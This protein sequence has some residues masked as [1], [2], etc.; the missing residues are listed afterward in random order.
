MI[1]GFLLSKALLCIAATSFAQFSGNYT[2]HGK[3]DAYTSYKGKIKVYLSKGIDRENG[4]IFDSA[5]LV[6]GSFSFAGTIAEPETQTITLKHPGSG[7]QDEL[8][9]VLENGRT[10]INTTKFL[11]DAVVTGSPLTTQLPEYEYIVSSIARKNDSLYR[12]RKQLDSADITLTNERYGQFS[13]FITKYPASYH[14][15]A[16]LQGLLID[17]NTQRSKGRL[18]DDKIL[19]LENLH[20]KIQQ[21]NGPGRKLDELSLSVRALRSNGVG[22]PVLHFTLP[23]LDGNPIDTKT[24]Q[25]K[26]FLIDFWGSWCVWCRKGHP[27]LKELYEQYKD[28]GF[29]IIAVAYEFGDEQQQKEKWKRAVKEDQLPWIHV[30]NG[31]GKDNMAEAYGVTAYPNKILVDRNGN[32]VLRTTDD[33]EKKLDAKLAELLN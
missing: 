12:L 5:D 6:K 15:I 1:K 18:A 25:G 20:Q 28:K 19:L 10:E 26:V 23:G 27:H 22:D 30:M 4:L 16:L 2:L 11:K 31:M 3:I 13:Q 21:S 29:E 9:I 14:S 24:L 8:L 33:P 17:A 32:I 7:Q